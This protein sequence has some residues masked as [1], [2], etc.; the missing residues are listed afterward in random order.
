M[1]FWGFQVWESIRVSSGLS[2]I[3]V[4]LSSVHFHFSSP[5]AFLAHSD[6]MWSWEMLLAQTNALCRVSWRNT[7]KK[8]PLNL[9]FLSAKKYFHCYSI[10]LSIFPSL[11]FFPRDHS[12]KWKKDLGRE[13]ERTQKLRCFLILHD[14]VTSTWVI[15][16]P[17]QMY[18]PHGRRERFC[19]LTDSHGFPLRNGQHSCFR[20]D[21]MQKGKCIFLRIVSSKLESCPRDIDASLVLLQGL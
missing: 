20:I 15:V 5:H 10:S 14:S 1:T 2:V 8:E 19:L 21:T 18:G 7:L 4:W 9:Q 3:W 13:R 11:S 6:A 17:R 16:S 12:E